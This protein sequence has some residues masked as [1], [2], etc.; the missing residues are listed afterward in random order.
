MDTRAHD[1]GRFARAVALAKLPGGVTRMG[2]TQFRV[3]GQHEPEYFVD[4]SV[5]PACYCGDMQNRGAQ[6]G[7]NCKHVLASRLAMK[8]PALDNSLMEFAYAQMQRAKELEQR[9]KE[10]TRR[11]RKA[12]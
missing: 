6:I 10:L 4:L 2:P 5:D 3:V 8:D 12:S 9:N 7:Y 11:R 1:P